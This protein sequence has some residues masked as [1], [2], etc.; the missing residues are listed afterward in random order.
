MG[1]DVIDPTDQIDLRELD[2]VTFRVNEQLWEKTDGVFVYEF[3]GNLLSIDL[4]QHT[5]LM[6][7]P[8]SPQGAL[9][10]L[11]LP[12]IAKD[13]SLAPNFQ[14]RD[15]PLPEVHRGREYDGLEF[16]GVWAANGAQ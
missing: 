1:V 15:T 14:L 16:F 7:K 10:A 6:D 13:A 3:K 8:G 4:R 2:L 5:H 11:V 9:V 12:N